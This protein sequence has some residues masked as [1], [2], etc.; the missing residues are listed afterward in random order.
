[1]KVPVHVEPGGLQQADR[2]DFRA[3]ARRADRHHLAAKVGHA[4][5]VLALE[6]RDLCV[7]RIEIR[8]CPG[9]HGAPRECGPAAQRIV[10]RVAE[11]E[12]DVRL[13][14]L[15]QLQVVD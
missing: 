11:R 9:P 7:A 13:A 4:I 12:G 10:E 8:Q 1:V 14:L 5:D 15:N 6:R 3:A 2:H